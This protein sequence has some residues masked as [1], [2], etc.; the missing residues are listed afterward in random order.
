MLYYSRRAASRGRDRR[1]SQ[2]PLNGK[3]VARRDSRFSFV[4][5]NLVKLVVQTL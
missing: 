5:K 2:V 1:R 4:Q 3:L